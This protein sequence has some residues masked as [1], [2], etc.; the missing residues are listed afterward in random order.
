MNP[1][2]IHKS[3]IKVLCEFCLRN[4]NPICC[5]CSGARYYFW[6]SESSLCYSASGERL[7]VVDDQGDQIDIIRLANEPPI[8]KLEIAVLIELMEMWVKASAVRSWK[9]WLNADG[10][11][12]CIG[13]NKFKKQFVQKDGMTPLQCVKES[14]REVLTKG[15][16]NIRT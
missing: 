7:T 5:I 1:S 14:Y 3:R 13:F 10:W 15:N 4:V 6:D 12:A 9:L 16:G 2:A 8:E 11:H